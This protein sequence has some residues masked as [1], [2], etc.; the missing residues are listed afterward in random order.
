MSTPSTKDIVAEMIKAGPQAALYAAFGGLLLLPVGWLA[1]FSEPPHIEGVAPVWV[2][3][4]PLALAMV[5]LF[6][7]AGYK[8]FVKTY[9]LEDQRAVAREE[10]QKVTGGSGPV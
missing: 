8:L 1:G 4:G 2:Y 6:V 10:A 7:L 9:H 5:V 3:L